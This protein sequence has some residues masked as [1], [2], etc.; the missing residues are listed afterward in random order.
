M[1]VCAVFVKNCLVIGILQKLCTSAAGGIDAVI[2]H[3]SEEICPCRLKK[4]VKGM[5]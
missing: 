2:K 4:A 5:V 1:S 3:K